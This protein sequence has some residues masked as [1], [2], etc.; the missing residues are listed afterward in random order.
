MKRKSLKIICIAFVAMLYA[1]ILNAQGETYFTEVTGELYKGTVADPF[2]P[3]IGYLA[4]SVQCTEYING[5][6]Y[7]VEFDF[8][9]NNFG[10]INTTTCQWTTIKSG[11][12]S[13]AVSLCYNPVDGQV[14]VTPWSGSGSKNPTFGTVD[15]T[16]GNFTTIATYPMDGDHTYFMAIDNDGVAYA[17]KN[18]SNQFG[19]IDLS[20][21]VFTPKGTIPI[22]AYQITNMSIDRETNE[23]YWLAKSSDFMNFCKYY[24]VDKETGALT[25]IGNTM[26]LYPQSFCIATDYNPIE[27]CNPATNLIAAYTTDC[28]AELTW[29]APAKTDFTYNVYRDDEFVEAVTTNSYVDEEF[30]MTV[31]HTWAVTVVCIDEE[32]EPVEYTLNT[33]CDACYPAKNLKIDV[34]ENCSSTLLTWEA[35]APD[36]LY[37][38]YRDA[39]LIKEKHKETSYTDTES[40]EGEHTWE[41]KVV[42]V[43]GE[44]E[45]VSATETCLIIDRISNVE[46]TTFFI[47]PNPAHNDIVI[48]ANVDFNTVEV[49][50]FLGQTVISQSATGNSAKLDISNLINGV[51][52]VHIV[53]EK[54]TS[55][56]KIIKQ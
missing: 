53:S 36:K 54:G 55:V 24:K 52:F 42:C 25:Q 48:Y 3:Q 26:P 41:V 38:I 5:V 56:K 31:G 14:Y 44:S 22:T 33:A 13:D 30:D 1:G 50:N 18:M 27:P 19:T 9:G 4:T 16:T 51:Y 8:I 46:L 21:G 40:A 43:A 29:D 2:G 49:I 35:P 32:S 47:V 17:I 20:T 15:I 7:G 10:T 11:F 6:I 37:N 34:A 12:G 23:L 45:P 28:K 39:K